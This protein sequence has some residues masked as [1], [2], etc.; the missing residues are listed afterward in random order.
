MS[1]SNQNGP[2]S[3]NPVEI[4]L[5]LVVLGFAGNS[6]R[7]LVNETQIFEPRAESPI[8]QRNARESAPQD[9][10]RS[11][12]STSSSQFATI[13]ISC[14]QGQRLLTQ[15]KKVRLL[16]QFCG[17]E[18][19]KNAEVTVTNSKNE[20]RATVFKEDKSKKFS[21]DYI[22]VDPGDNP[23]TIEFQKNNA[24]SSHRLPITVIRN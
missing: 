1:S 6:A 15:A 18:S 2:K 10:Q 12:A 7:R 8:A 23:I 22:D 11:P 3:I 21:T 14:D 17:T 4:L 20:V 5:F 24:N 19:G 9:S 16:G 13:S